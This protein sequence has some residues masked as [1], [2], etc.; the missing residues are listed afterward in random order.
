MCF[1]LKI[2]VLENILVKLF[3]RMCAFC[4]S[5]VSPPLPPRKGGECSEKD[6]RFFHFTDRSFADCGQISSC[7]PAKGGSNIEQ[8]SVARFF[9]KTKLVFAPIARARSFPPFTEGAGGGCITQTVNNL[10]LAFLPFAFCLLL[11]YPSAQAQAYQTFITGDTADVTTSTKGGIVLSGGAGEVDAAMRWFLQQSGGG[12]VVVIRASGADGYNDY[13]FS[14]LGEPVNSVQTFVLPSLAAANAPYVAHKIRQ[15]EA[16][17]IAGGDQASYVNWW[18]DGPV[19]AAIHYLIHDKKVPIGGISA[20]MAV[21]GSAYFAALNGSVTS[22]EGLAN[23]YNS[24]MTIGHDDF[25]DHIDLQDVITDTHY[26]DPDRRG[27]HLAFM[28]RLAEDF[29]IR[30]RGIACEEYTAVCIDSAG[31]ARVYGSFPESTDYAYFL[32]TNCTDDFSP[33]TCVP[34]Q[35]LHWQRDNAAVLVYRLPG[36][37]NGEAT[38]QLRD[39]KTGTGGQWQNWWVESGVLKTQ[40]NASGPSCI[41]PVTAPNAGLELRIFPNPAA[42]QVVITTDAPGVAASLEVYDSQGK[43]VAAI[44]NWVGQ[45]KLSTQAWP[46]GF[47]LFRIIFAEGAVMKKVWVR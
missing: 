24:R 31:L 17:W 5:R 15:A 9:R 37:T 4:R 12:D 3:S 30:A 13:L 11:I 44:P 38:F 45:I 21:Q 27:R 46:T 40:S 41:T 28:A 23:P 14:E 22:P 19:E 32:Q 2:N 26:D 20:G 29:G 36:R 10:W 47:Y 42:G 35:P 7:S 1:L 33:E 18:K 43:R 8:S 25:L 6:L 34:G 39:W 16:L